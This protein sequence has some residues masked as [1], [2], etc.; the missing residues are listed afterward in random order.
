MKIMYRLGLFIL[1]NFL[2]ITQVFAANVY[3]GASV[4]QSKTDLDG[5]DNPLGYKLFLGA[6][7]TAFAGF[8]L[9]YIDLDKTLNG[10]VEHDTTGVELTGIGIFPFGND[11]EIFLKLG[12]F[13]RDT[14]IYVN[15]IDIGNVNGTD[16]AYGLGVNF[17]MSPSSL[18]RMEYQEFRDDNNLDLTYSFLSLGIMLKFN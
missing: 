13:S 6:Q 2:F 18:L 10:S 8:E 17:P 9:A 11:G 4:G 14:Q 16:L 15:G 5:Y 3:V 12:I 7:L 1:L